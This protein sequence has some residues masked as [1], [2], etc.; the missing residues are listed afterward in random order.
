MGQNLQTQS[1][2]LSTGLPPRQR[3]EQ[4]VAMVRYSTSR[5]QAVEQ[6]RK[7][8]GCYPHANPPDASGYATAIADVLEQ[9]P[10]GIVQACCSPLTGLPRSREFP[11]TVAAVV[12]WCDLRVAG[13][14]NL[15]RLGPPQSEVV[16]TEEHRATMRERLAEFFKQWK[17]GAFNRVLE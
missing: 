2:R 8:V 7:L 9:Y 13:A 10:L 14:Q 15:V 3:W 16:H 11:P 12:A 4:A 5:P 1:Q 17:S 6:A